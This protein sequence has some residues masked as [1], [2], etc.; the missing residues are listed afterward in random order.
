[1]NNNVLHLADVDG[2]GHKKWADVFAANSRVLATINETDNAIYPN[3]FKIQ[4]SA[5]IYWLLDTT[6]GDLNSYKLRVVR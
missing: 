1:L 6:L 4:G 2:F 5:R 3:H